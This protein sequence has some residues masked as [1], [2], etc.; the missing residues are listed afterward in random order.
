M[1]CPPFGFYGRRHPP[2]TAALHGLLF[3][4]QPRRIKA[5][6]AAGRLGPEP[7]WLPDRKRGPLWVTIFKRPTTKHSAAPIHEFSERLRQNQTSSEPERPRSRASTGPVRTPA[8]N[9][10]RSR[11]IARNNSSLNAS[12]T[13]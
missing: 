2:R 11:P 5:Q 6:Q 10:E 7:G 12:S 13:P 4:P 9:S 8:S 1:A 3:R